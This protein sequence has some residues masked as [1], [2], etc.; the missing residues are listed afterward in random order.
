MGSNL[1]IRLQ[2]ARQASGLGLRKL[3]ELVGLSHLKY[4]RQAGEK[5]LILNGEKA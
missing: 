2:R 5:N 4:T 1:G 3:G